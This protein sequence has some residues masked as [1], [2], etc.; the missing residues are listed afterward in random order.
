[1]VI[2]ICLLQWEIDLILCMYQHHHR[3]LIPVSG[4]GITYFLLPFSSITRHLHA[5]SFYC[6]MPFFTQSIHLF[7]GRLCMY[8]CSYFMC[9]HVFLVGLVYF[10]IWTCA[11]VCVSYYYYEAIL[12]QIFIRIDSAISKQNRQIKL[13]SHSQ[14]I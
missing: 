9:V 7:L 4:V 13:L 8:V 2:D 5:L 14:K 6:H 11:C 10:W 1:V 3:P 12:I